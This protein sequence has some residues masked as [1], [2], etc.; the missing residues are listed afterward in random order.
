[1]VLPQPTSPCNNRCMGWDTEI[2]LR[3]SANTRCWADVN[4]NGK[5]D[6]NA[7][8]HAPTWA[9]LGAVLRRREYCARCKDNCCANNSSN[10]ILRHAGCERFSKLASSI[11]GGGL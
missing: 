8:E 3:I 10:F 7:F 5:L 1:M 11:V 9:K 2:S 4:A 6:K